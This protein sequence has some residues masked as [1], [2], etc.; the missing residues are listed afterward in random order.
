[1]HFKLPLW[2]AAIKWCPMHTHKKFV[3]KR[4]I[5][6]LHNSYAFNGECVCKKEKYGLI[7]RVGI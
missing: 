4:F 5:I 3:Q 1:M 6:M 7:K 2:E